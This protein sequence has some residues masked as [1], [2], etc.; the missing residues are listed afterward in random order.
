MQLINNRYTDVLM[1][2]F[3][4]VGLI[5]CSSGTR[6]RSL[7]RV[8]KPEAQNQTEEGNIRAKKYRSSYY[9]VSKEIADIF[10]SYGNRDPSAWQTSSAYLRKTASSEVTDNIK[11]LAKLARRR[12]EEGRKT[13]KFLYRNG[14]VMKQIHRLPSKDKSVWKSV[15]KKIKPFGPK[16]KQLLVQY[17]MRYLRTRKFQYRAYATETLAEMGSEVTV[18]NWK[19][20]QKMARKARKGVKKNKPIKGSIVLLRGMGEVLVRSGHNS[21]IKRAVRHDSHRIRI[22]MAFAMGN[23]DS[24]SFLVDQLE[25]LAL[26]DRRLMIRSEAIASLDR[27]NSPETI[28]VLVK[29][30]GSK[31][32]ELRQ[33]A[34][35]VLRAFPER[36][37]VIQRLV[38]WESN[39]QDSDEKL[40]KRLYDFLEDLTDQSNMP[41]NK[42]A[43]KQWYNQIY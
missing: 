7:E 32:K 1:V 35:E 11:Y 41:R 40:Q 9:F 22:A 2:L 43:W 25:V 3:L 26:E 27:L 33:E 37:K 10:L 28:P 21:L 30:L 18:T 42:A 13:R 4:T 12:G 20:M 23:V 36:K 17:L 31:Y 14:K 34:K 29:I 19:Y 24:S 6:N 39:H 16:G 15:S 8:K 38:F 5:S